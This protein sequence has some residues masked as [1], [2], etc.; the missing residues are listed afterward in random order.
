M[1]LPRGQKNPHQSQHMFRFRPGLPCNPIHTLYYPSRRKRRCAICSHISCRWWTWTNASMQPIATPFTDTMAQRRGFYRI[2]WIIV[3]L[4]V[5]KT[6]I[7]DLWNP[8]FSRL[9]QTIITRLLA[10]GPGGT[11]HFSAKDMHHLW[12]RCIIHLP[13]IDFELGML[14]FCIVGMRFFVVPSTCVSCYKLGTSVTFP[15]RKVRHEEIGWET[16][17]IFFFTITK[18]TINKI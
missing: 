1:S 13:G 16:G 11:V 3:S 10:S 14:V 5:L 9:L 6:H 8:T 2:I 18:G 4:K 12:Q 15:F 7:S 17:I